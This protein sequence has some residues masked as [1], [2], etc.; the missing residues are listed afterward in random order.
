M[1]TT[2]R[3]IS[4][5]LV[6]V[7]L[8][9]SLTSCFL[10]DEDPAA[11]IAEAEAAL[12]DKSYTVTSVIEYTSE[13]EKMKDALAA[14][15]TVT[16]FTEVKGD[17]FRM[18]TSFEKDGKENGV[19]YTY[20]DG[21]L[22]TVLDELG[23]TTKVSETVTETDRRE[24]AEQLGESASIASIRIGIATPSRAVLCASCRMSSEKATQART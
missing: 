24:L 2:K 1:K 14:F 16:S 4:A 12:A 15:T 21:V 11:L 17:S 6:A 10:I 7:I 8:L 9:A 20:V 18:S 13:D 23:V 5:L 22:Y 19:I 3:I